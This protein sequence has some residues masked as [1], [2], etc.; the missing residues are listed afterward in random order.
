MDNQEG[1]SKNKVVSWLYTDRKDRALEPTHA[2]QN[3]SSNREGGRKAQLFRKPKESGS[4]NKTSQGQNQTAKSATQ[5][6]NQNPV[7]AAG[8]G[9]PYN[10]GAT[11]EESSA[12]NSL[13]DLLDDSFL[14]EDSSSPKKD[15]NQPGEQYIFRSPEEAW[16]ETEPGKELMLSMGKQTL[17]FCDSPSKN[18]AHGKSLPSNLF[19]HPIAANAQPTA[20][21]LLPPRLFDLLLNKT[22]ST[23]RFGEI[24]YAI[25]S[26]VWGD[27]IELDGKDFNIDW[28]IPVSSRRKLIQMLEFARIVGGERYVWIDI[29]CLDQN[30]NN[31]EEIARM[32]SYYTDA[33]VCLVWLDKAPNQEQIEWDGILDAI[34][35]F[36]KLFRLDMHGHPNMTPKQMIEE[37]LCDVRMDER[38]SFLLTKKVL[39][40]EKALWF[41]RV[42][43]LQEAVIPENLMLCTPERYMIS[44]AQLF[45]AI[46]LCAMMVNPLLDQGASASVAI[47]NTLQNSEVWKI[48]RLRQLYRKRQVSFWHIVQATKSRKCLKDQDRVF[49]ILGLVQGVDSPIDLTL[50]AETVLENLH[51]NY[52]KASDF[53]A[54]MFLSEQ[55]TIN[56]HPSSR[57]FL[58]SGAL[59]TKRR[60]SHKITVLSDNRVQLQDVGFDSITKYHALHGVGNMIPWQKQHPKILEATTDVAIDVARAW[61]LDVEAFPEDLRTMLV[62]TIYGFGHPNDM[63]EEVFQA[64][65]EEALTMYHRAVQKAMITW[66]SISTLIQKIENYAIVVIWTQHCGPVLAAMTEVPKQF[67]FIVTPSTYVDE[68]GEGFLIVT[69]DAGAT[70]FRKIGVGLSSKMKP[71]YLNT[72][73]VSG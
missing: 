27:T 55:K 30:Q 63:I 7:A 18:W 41:R 4:K 40:L 22:V 46:S 72:I 39:A 62:F 47:L 6:A 51:A 73:I 14:S 5:P 61:D 66:S 11:S 33:T 12:N 1:G 24:S 65:G 21:S 56:Y 43:T 42:W 23:G 8:P 19:G 48:L 57:G 59:A 44:G 68:P 9:R 60:E 49:G 32:K 69:A 16:R 35:S 71:R 38:Q 58:V 52:L 37:G 50:P 10:R 45:S 70:V 15:V 2:G 53:S 25:V 29:L 31:E 28:Q 34:E 54:L 20:P 13:N 17:D 36:N 3:E 67:S 64:R 26:H